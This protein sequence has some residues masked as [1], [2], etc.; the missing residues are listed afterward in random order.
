MLSLLFFS[1]LKECHKSFARTKN[2]LEAD[3]EEIFEKLDYIIDLCSKI[4]DEDY[5]FQFLDSFFKCFKLE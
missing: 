2:I 1:R 4:E 5:W 3:T